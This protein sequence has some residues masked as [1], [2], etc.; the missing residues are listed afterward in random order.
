MRLKRSTFFVALLVCPFLSGCDGP[1]S[2]NSHIAFSFLDWLILGL[3]LLGMLTIGLY[4]SRKN[5][6]QK[7]FFLGGGKMNPV[8]LG[9]SLFATVTSSIS[10]LAWP[11]ETISYGPVMLSGAI[12]FPLVYYV[13]GWLMIPKFKK[14]N[15]TS[16]YEILEIRL[17]VNVRMLAT[18]FFLS[19]RFLWMATII[20]VS[21][22]VVVLSLFK[23][24]PSYRF[25]LAAVLM[26]VAII[27][28]FMGG[29]KG[30]V[31][32]DVVQT[33]IL[34][35]GL[36]IVL[37]IVVVHF[38][39]IGVLVPDHWLE[40]WGEL[41]IGIHPKD[42]SSIGSAVL[43]T[44]VWY[45]ATSGSDQLT[46][47]RFLASEDAKAA[48]R[49]FLVSLVA[50]FIGMVLLSLVGF[51][52][53]AYFEANPQYLSRGQNLNDQAD[54]LFPR[55]IMLVLPAGLSGFLIVGI[56]SAAMSSLSSGL[57]STASVISEDIIKRFSSKSR[58]TV[59]ELKVAKNLSLIVGIITLL[60]SIAIPYVKGNLIDLAVK[61]VNLFVSPLFVLFFM[62]LFVPFA[63][64]GVL[65]SGALPALR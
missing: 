33:V 52:L 46:I 56:L 11:G 28:T 13:V 65:L 3:Y 57:N 21:V 55:F 6:T 38:R 7:D 14:M 40:Q 1:S 42:R 48:R 41:R 35:A 24:D 36:I 17:G 37:V 4:Y 19:M 31:V 32:T 43:M 61:V 47:Q 25:L 2:D 62:A 53:I 60:L 15:V 51:A 18:F 16:A 22:E 10:Y 58:R 9:L 64:A 49:T 12:S 45:I 29:I 30:V 20:Y 39:S 63:T 34:M 8:A 26:L 44:F 54:T 27:Y 59:N 5:K 23:V 50:G